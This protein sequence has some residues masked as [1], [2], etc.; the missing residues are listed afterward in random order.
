MM[1]CLAVY[2]HM[3]RLCEHVLG[4]MYYGLSYCVFIA[5]AAAAAAA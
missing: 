1:G 3:W 5:A 4:R 2:N